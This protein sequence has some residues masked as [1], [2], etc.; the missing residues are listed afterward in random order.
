MSVIKGVVVKTTSPAVTDDNTKGFYVGFK[1]VNTATDTT[2]NCADASTGTAVWTI[3]STPTSN[4][5][6]PPTIPLGALLASGAS[7]FINGGAGVYLSFSGTADDTAFLNI[8]LDFL[9][10]N[11]TGVDLAI[12]LHWRLS[13]NGGV[14]D[15]V[16]W[17]L[18]YAL[19]GNGDNST[20]T[21][22]NV[23]QQDVDVSAEVEDINFSTQLGTMTGV[24][25]ADTLMVT[26]LR[27]SSGA[28]ADS[29]SGNAELVS[30]EIIKV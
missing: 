26:L 6:N 4:T 27:N 25:G 10:L 29:F 8:S 22:T 24:L 3:S 9:G 7:F 14:G 21:V 13:A 30:L 19:V 5:W 28:G 15:T 20:T 12:R 17:V 18:S 1:W 23:A 16:G 2:Y 11:Y